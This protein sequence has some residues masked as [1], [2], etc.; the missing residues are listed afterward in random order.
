MALSLWPVSPV[1]AFQSDT[2]PSPA[3]TESDRGLY[4]TAFDTLNGRVIVNLPDDLSAGDTI[5]GTVETAPAGKSSEETAKN[6]DELNGL[7]VEV[8]ET[9]TPSS[10]GLTK[11]TVPSNSPS[12]IPLVVRDK[13]GKEIARTAIPVKPKAQAGCRN[14][15]QSTLKGATAGVVNNPAAAAGNS[16]LAQPNSIQIGKKGEAI[17][18]SGCDYQLPTNAQPGRPLEVHGPFDGDLK[19]TKVLVAGKEAKVLAE[20]PRKAVAVSPSA[21]VGSAV[22]EVMKRG[23]T[24]AKGSV[25]NIGVK[26]AAG[27]L[28]LMKDETTPLTVTVLGLEGLNEPVSLRLTNKSPT[29]VSLEGG[30]QQSAT[31]DPQTVKQG[32]YVMNRTLTGIRPGGFSIT[33]VVDAHQKAASQPGNAIPGGGLQPTY[34]SRQIPG[35]VRSPGGSGSPD[36]LPTSAANIPRE[37]PS[38][39]PLP[40]APCDGTFDDF[41]YGF[42]WQT[43]GDGVFTPVSGNLN[44]GQLNPPGMQPVNAADS[45]AGAIGGT[46]WNIPFRNGHQGSWWVWSGFAGNAATG[47]MTSQEFLIHDPFVDFLIGGGDALTT[48]A[49]EVDV[50]QGLNFVGDYS[51]A[52]PPSGLPNVPSSGG[53]AAVTPNAADVARQIAGAGSAPV[54]N[55]RRVASVGGD[56]IATMHRV[57]LGPIPAALHGRRARFVVTDNSTTAAIAVDDF[58]CSN[59]RYESPHPV[60]GIADLHTH[61]MS[62]LG[63]GGLFWGSPTG[64]MDQA[65]AACPLHHGGGDNLNIKV[66]AVAGALALQGLAG[67]AEPLVTSQTGGVVPPGT[68]AATA[69]VAGAAAIG[70]SLTVDTSTVVVMA[71]PEPHRQFPVNTAGYPSFAGWP[72]SDSLIHQQMYIDW[73]RRA[74]QGGLRLVQ[75]DVVNNRVL[76]WGMGHEQLDD[77]AFRA[78]IQGINNMVAANS[79]W[80]AIATTPAQARQIINQGK[81]AVVLGVEVDE[82]EMLAR[83]SLQ[84][85]SAFS[86]CLIRNVYTL[87]PDQMGGVVPQIVQTLRDAGVRH[88]IP[89][90]LA[91]NSFGGTAVYMDELNIDNY[92]LHDR[93]YDVRDGT[94]FGVDA[95]LTN[96]SIPLISSP[97]Y[98]SMGYGMVNTQ[99]LTDAGRL[100]VRELMR[101]GMIVDTAHMSE[102]AAD[103]ILGVPLPAGAGPAPSTG[104]GLVFTGCS[105]VTNQACLDAAYPVMESHTGIRE[106]SATGFHTERELSRAQADRIYSIG[107]LIGLGVMPDHVPS[108]C[109]GSTRSFVPLLREAAAHTGGHGIALGTDVNGFNGL[110]RPR[111]GS[112]ACSDQSL[113]PGRDAS[114]GSARV[115]YVTPGTAPTG[116]RLVQSVAGTRSF[117]LNTDGWA[118]YGMM[119]DFLQDASSVGLAAADREPIFASAEEFLEMWEKDCRIAARMGGGEACR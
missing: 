26:L 25:R 113:N 46:Y 59:Q 106:I 111:I 89:I 22:I 37:T 58:R 39:A 102:L 93:F 52:P 76:A 70:F 55:W 47:S 66:C 60:W 8:A 88:V 61:P 34:I 73:I 75:A 104:P 18:S 9:K 16:Q 116:E 71:I 6:Q 12:T 117:D 42:F 56:G 43:D 115:S 31:I 90:H 29:V 11:F 64:P 62:H 5:S 80:M 54:A 32:Q 67:L 41:E 84:S 65:L 101:E 112:H 69:G 49:L 81:L 48:V 44:V 28:T 21:V 108:S 74:Y 38:V 78:E 50:P 114:E 79:S 68:V 13:G 51:T 72:Y 110:T 91:D 4:T 97:D 30:E 95:R 23:V 105:D 99:G 14:N 36:L 63:F 119:P 1:A 15:P 77:D 96:P 53:I 87:P 94:P 33:T 109:P 27:K 92:F 10:D 83:D 100:L 20:S 57:S 82:L 40:P 103:E 19:T 107:G 7:V 86:D 98:N 3:T 35:G 2:T 45:I 85:S 24:V 17:A 118:H